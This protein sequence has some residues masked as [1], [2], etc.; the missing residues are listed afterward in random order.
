MWLNINSH[1]T[2]NVFHSNIQFFTQMVFSLSLLNFLRI[3][4]L[5]FFLKSGQETTNCVNKKNE[6]LSWK[7]EISPKSLPFWPQ[8]FAYSISQQRLRDIWSQSHIAYQTLW[9]KAWRLRQKEG[10][11][12]NFWRFP[13]SFLLTVKWSNDYVLNTLWKS[14]LNASLICF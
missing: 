4:F 11:L 14:F 2:I 8:F 10:L 13:I 3:L 1:E 7:C 9:G 5:W 6:N 12:M